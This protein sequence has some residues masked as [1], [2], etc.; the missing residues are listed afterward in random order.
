MELKYLYA[1][2]SDFSQLLTSRRIEPDPVRARFRLIQFLH[3]LVGLDS[4]HDSDVGYPMK[5]AEL[6]YARW[7]RESHSIGCLKMV[8]WEVKLTQ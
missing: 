8:C 6:Y 5:I 1:A 4:V 3:R 7:L 2:M